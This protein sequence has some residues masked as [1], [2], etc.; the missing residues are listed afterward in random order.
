MCIYISV[1]AKFSKFSYQQLN[2]GYIDVWVVIH[3]SLACFIVMF[4]KRGDGGDLFPA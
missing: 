4:T 1:K 3:A 2:F